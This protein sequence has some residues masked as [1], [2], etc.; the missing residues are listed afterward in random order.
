[1][2][3][4]DAGWVLFGL[5]FA[6]GMARGRLE[7]AT[8]AAFRRSSDLGAVRVTSA[9]SG[10][11]GELF[12]RSSVVSMTGAGMSIKALPLEL[13]SPG[14][15]GADVRLFR[16]SLANS[17]LA[18]IPLKQVDAWIPDVRVD[19]GAL[20][21]DRRLKVR[22]AG[23]GVVHAS[24]T[25]KALASLVT[26]RMPAL[27]D[28]VVTVTPTAIEVTGRI[29]LFGAAGRST[30]ILRPRVTEN[31]DL[32]L[33][34][35]G[36]TMNGSPSVGALLRGLETTMNPALSPSRDLKLGL[37]LRLRGV[38]LLPGEL[39]LEAGTAPIGSRR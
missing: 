13:G 29:A 17:D 26:A 10:P 7:E 2:D 36:A 39:V 5:L 19:P 34:V 32:Y 4:R 14:G 24:I 37:E 11:V 30:T 38:R 8:A 18:G 27:K 12:A 31:G 9:R 1:M 6:S 28:A 25:E 16:I 21:R 15:P 22:S 23:S 20:M 33:D 35:V 3:I